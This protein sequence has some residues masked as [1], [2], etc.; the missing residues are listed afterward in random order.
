MKEGVY[1]IGPA[2]IVRR[3][4]VYPVRYVGA[5]DP[6]CRLP[7]VEVVVPVQRPGVGARPVRID[8][9]GSLA[10]PRRLLSVTVIMDGPCPGVEPGIMRHAELLEA[11]GLPVRVI[12][13]PR[14][15]GQIAVLDEAICESGAEVVALTELLAPLGRDILLKLARVH[16]EATRSMSCTEVLDFP[17][18]P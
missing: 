11:A 8:C 6:S 4:E 7:S 9:I 12:R 10:Y 3:Q 14:Y 5:A 17:P 18:R 15:R 16:I 13:H 1:W 2:A